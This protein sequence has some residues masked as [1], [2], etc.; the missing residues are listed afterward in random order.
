MFK[1]LVFLVALEPILLVFYI[2]LNALNSGKVHEGLPYAAIC[3]MC[4]SYFA[5]GAV[6]TFKYVKQ[7]LK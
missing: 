5:K 2:T 1:M 7:F 6:D 4:V 3:L